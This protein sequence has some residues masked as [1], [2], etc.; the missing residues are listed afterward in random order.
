M[1]ATLFF[2]SINVT[3]ISGLMTELYETNTFQRDFE[4]SEI[5]P[6]YEGDSMRETLKYSEER[7]LHD[8]RSPRLRVIVLRKKC[9]SAL[10]EFLLSFENA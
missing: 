3:V 4:S 9:P 7:I 1:C 10:Y 2:F 5:A 6:V 8:S